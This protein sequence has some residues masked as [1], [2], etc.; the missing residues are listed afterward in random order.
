M[1]DEA[2]EARR[3]TG[4]NGRREGRKERAG[5]EEENKQG[6]KASLLKPKQQNIFSSVASTVSGN[7]NT[8]LSN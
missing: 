1:K 7:F 4:S 6:L 8:K 3:K 2:A 5:R